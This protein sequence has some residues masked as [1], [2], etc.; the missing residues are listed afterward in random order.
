[1]T[2]HRIDGRYVP[3]PSFLVQMGEHTGKTDK[4]LLQDMDCESDEQAGCTVKEFE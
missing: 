2:L 1:L 4:A 3:C